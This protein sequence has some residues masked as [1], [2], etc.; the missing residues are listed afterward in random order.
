MLAP[1]KEFAGDPLGTIGEKTSD[2][3]AQKLN[4]MSLLMRPDT[5]EA[6]EYFDPMYISQSKASDK[7]AN[8]TASPSMF[9][10]QMGS[11]GLLQG[12]YEP[13]PNPMMGYGGSAYA[14]TMK[15]FSPAY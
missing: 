14:E 2:F 8:I 6:P 12:G 1:Y 5:P 7:Y 4:P 13:M 11:L 3:V 10:Q 15:N 9:V